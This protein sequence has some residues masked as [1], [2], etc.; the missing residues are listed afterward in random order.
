[1]CIIM[2]FICS[3][4]PILSI[5]FICSSSLLLAILCLSTSTAHPLYYS[6]I[7]TAATLHGLL[8]NHQGLIIIKVFIAVGVSVTFCC[9]RFCNTTCHILST[10]SLVMTWLSNIIFIRLC[11]GTRA[12]SS[13]H[14]LHITVLYMHNLFIHTVYHFIMLLTIHVCIGVRAS[15]YRVAFITLCMY[16]HYFGVLMDMHQVCTCY[17]TFMCV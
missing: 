9:S 12:S 15:Y 7:F 10:L 3:L 11:T 14:S 17:H 16:H 13:H 4:Q 1:M 8:I 2:M 6:S 5:L